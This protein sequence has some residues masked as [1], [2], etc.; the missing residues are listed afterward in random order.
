M[1]FF[2]VAL[3]C[4][5]SRQPA[6]TG[7]RN[8]LGAGRV[9]QLLVI[10]DDSIQQRRYLSGWRFPSVAARPRR[11]ADPASGA[12][13]CGRH[14]LIWCC[15]R[16]CRRPAGRG[17]IAGLRAPNR[18]ARVPEVV[19]G[20]TRIWTR[21]RAGP[22]P[23]RL[24]ILSCLSIARFPTNAQP[25]APAGSGRG[26]RGRAGLAD[27]PAFDADRRSPEDRARVRRRCCG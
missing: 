11:A 12:K 21:D 5:C 10:V 27:A 13:F 17:L 8:L 18:L 4:L 6:Y 20:R 14:R 15:L 25:V 23:G 1:H 19:V 24:I 3:G 16:R 9:G 2:P 22:R 7:T 26:Y